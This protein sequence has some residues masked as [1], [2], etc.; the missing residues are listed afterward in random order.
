MAMKW[1]ISNT[2]GT[3]VVMGLQ[4]DGGREVA[5]F[6]LFFFTKIVFTYKSSL[7]HVKSTN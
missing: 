1:I 5:L 6:S 2:H 3:L 4:S 7:P